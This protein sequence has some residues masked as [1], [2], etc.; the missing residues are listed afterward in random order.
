MTIVP[1]FEVTNCKLDDTISYV[2][3]LHISYILCDILQ[4]LI[5]AMRIIV[6]L[7]LEN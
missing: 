2:L 1:H 5:Y 3:L 7:N 6:D 4:K